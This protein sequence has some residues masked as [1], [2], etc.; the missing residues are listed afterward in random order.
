MTH[1]RHVFARDNEYV[2]VHRRRRQPRTATG[3]SLALVLLCLGVLGFVVVTLWP[4]I[5][6]LLVAAVVYWL[7]GQG[8]FA[9]VGR[10]FK[11]DAANARQGKP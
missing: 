6:A 4:I 1:R 9:A 11:Q 2:V 5:L 10:F 3:P 7:Y 8:F